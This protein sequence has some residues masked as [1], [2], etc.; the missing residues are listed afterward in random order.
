MVKLWKNPLHRLFQRRRSMRTW[1]L[2]IGLCY[3][4][5]SVF[6][7]FQHQH[8]GSEDVDAGSN[9]LTISEVNVRP[10]G[11]AQSVP[12]SR[13]SLRQIASSHACKIP[14]AHKPAFVKAGKTRLEHCLACEWQ[15][16][17]VSAAL[18]P[19]TLFQTEPI[20]PPRVVTTLPRC[21]RSRAIATSSR[22]PPTV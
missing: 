12:A 2:L 4:I 7:P 3:L 10:N 11:V 15:A 22:G 9:A 1:T 5:L 18:Q 21:L 16:M 6:L 13:Y 14:A 19:L 17:Q 20:T 8:I